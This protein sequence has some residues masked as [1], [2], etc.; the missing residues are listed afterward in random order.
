MAGRKAPGTKGRSDHDERREIN[1]KRHK[2]KNGLCVI[3]FMSCL[4]VLTRVKPRAADA[5]GTTPSYDSSFARR[6]SIYWSEM[7]SF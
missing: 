6:V 7:T 2:G 4:S 5:L 3:V 1:R